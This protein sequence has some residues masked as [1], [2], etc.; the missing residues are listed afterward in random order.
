MAVSTKRQMAVCLLA[1]ALAACGASGSE[2]VRSDGIGPVSPS[3][4]SEVIGS[5]TLETTTT[6]AI[7]VGSESCASGE[8]VRLREDA[9]VVL[10][11][12]ASEDGLTVFAAEY[13]LSGPTEGLW[14]QWGQ[15]IVASTGLHYSA[16]GDELGSDGNSYVYRYDPATRE[17]TRVMDVLSL[18]DHQPGAWGYGKI[19]SQMVEDAC[20]SIWFF[21]YW[22]TQEDLVYGK[23][24]EGDLLLQLDP[25]SG[26]ITNHGPVVGH[27]GVPSLRATSDG[28][29]LVAEAVE[30]GTEEGSL[31]VIDT[32]TAGILHDV[33]DPGHVGFRALAEDAEG[34]ILYSYYD[35]RLMALDVAT[36]EVTDPGTH[37]PADEWDFLRA[38]TPLTSDGSFYAAMQENDVL[39]RVDSNGQITEL[40]SA[41]EYTT[42]LAM[43]PDERYVYFMPGAHGSSWEVG[44]YVRVI[45]T[46]SGEISNVVSLLEPFEEELGLLVGGTYSINYYEGRLII[47]VNASPIGDDSGFG[48]VVLVVVEGL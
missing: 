34:R 10:E 4:S 33:S 36:G 3:S 26:T 11:E 23:G 39:F 44:G 8:I 1:I 48:T 30:P 21:T 16:V 35:Q 27:R 19:H 47:G 24:Y 38:A 7:S 6:G 29:Y 22:G 31:V 41:G 12:I 45:D 18:T 42:S 2:S 40:G 15:G 13:P 25:V 9:S 37:L 43:T 32:A 20:G 46:E 28:R 5:S 17:L 14:S